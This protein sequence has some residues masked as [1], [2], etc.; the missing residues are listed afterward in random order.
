MKHGILKITG[1]ILDLKKFF[2]VK[3]QLHHQEYNLL[4]ME[5]FSYESQ[6]HVLD[7]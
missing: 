6:Q 4:L 1:K 2:F 5:I 7:V 3:F